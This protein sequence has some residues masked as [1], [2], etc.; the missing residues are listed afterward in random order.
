MEP[1]A[2]VLAFYDPSTEEKFASYYQWI[3]RV[4]R[5]VG[6]AVGRHP[7]VVLP[8]SELQRNPVQA[9]DVSTPCLRLG[10]HGSPL[11]ARHMGIHP[12]SE[13]GIHRTGTPSDATS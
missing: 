3:G 4:T 2:R 1:L 8:K 5:A 11:V 7:V 10:C 12:F 13:R 6:I 9:H